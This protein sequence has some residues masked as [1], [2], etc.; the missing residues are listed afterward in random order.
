MRT[1]TARLLPPVCLLLL[2]ACSGIPSTVAPGEPP[3]A[4]GPTVV[5]LVRHAEKATDG[6]EDPSL[7]PAGKQRAE[8]LVEVA[9]S[10]GV[11]AILA[12]QY[13]RTRETAQPLADRLGIPVAVHEV[14][15]GGA[16]AHAT[17]LARDVLERHRGQSVLV[18]G[19]SNTV[20]LLVE[21]LAGIPVQP[22]ADS[23][24]DRLFVVVV[25]PSGPARLVQT[26]YG[27]RTTT[28]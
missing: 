21:A 8:A 2:V 9:G 6:G 27:V 17:A 10:A 14:V 22:I 7:T 1:V 20:P 26:R 19:H 5:L 12:T 24:Y 13:R 15:S 25:P 16:Q 11:S 18:V 4:S 3:S 28:P 23:E